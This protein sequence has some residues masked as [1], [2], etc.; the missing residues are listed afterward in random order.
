MA[1]NA[2]HVT[3]GQPSYS[4]TPPVFQGAHEAGAS[5]AAAAPCKS[6][7]H[8]AFQQLMRDKLESGTIFGNSLGSFLKFFAPFGTQNSFWCRLKKSPSFKH[9]F[10]YDESVLHKCV[11]ASI[12]A[13]LGRGR[14]RVA[15]VDTT[16]NNTSLICAL[17]ISIPLM[18]FGELSSNNENWASMMQTLSDPTNGD[19]FCQRLPDSSRFYSNFCLS[20]FQTYYNRLFFATISCFYT[21]CASLFLAVF[22]YMCRPS[23]GSNC[24]STMQLIE[25]FKIEVRDS[26][27][28]QR[29]VQRSGHSEREPETNAEELELLRR[30]EDSEVFFHAKFLAENKM[31]ELKNHEF[32][33]WYKSEKEHVMIV[34]PIICYFVQKS[35]LASPVCEN[36][37]LHVR[38]APS[39]VFLT[40]LHQEEDSLSLLVI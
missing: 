18:I 2:N 16:V 8:A 33:M 38:F 20:R 12:S 13:E 1:R 17:V 28:R 21:A 24:L 14:V 10:V 15:D 4:D 26:L 35:T 9:L 5:G 23:E 3:G 7:H 27:R 37:R 29:Q 22:Y 11:D 34:L 36:E 19:Q 39:L 32:Y 31:Q 30:L 40:H 25:A 6:V